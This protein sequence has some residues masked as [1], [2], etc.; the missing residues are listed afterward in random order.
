MFNVL[1]NIFM[2]RES[3][4]FTP[5]YLVSSSSVSIVASRSY[6]AASILLPTLFLEFIFSRRYS[7][8]VVSENI[9]F[10]CSIIIYENL[11]VFL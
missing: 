5:S 11:V 10:S 7:K 1:A 8:G 3:V 6:L 4:V 9:L 2:S